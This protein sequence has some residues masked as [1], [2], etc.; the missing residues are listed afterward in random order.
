MTAPSLHSVEIKAFVP[1][2][3]FT[4]SL[5]FYQRIGFDAPWVGEDLAYL[6]HEDCSFLLQRFYLAAHAD[7]F[8]MH[9]LVTD[10]DAW[11]RHI[12]ASGVV[13]EFGVRVSEPADQPWRLR[14]FSLIDPSG[15]CWRIGHNLPQD[16]R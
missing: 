5:R 11:H 4:Q 3:D 15:V 7:N 13:E 1:A 16:G 10:A 12:V 9:L 2:R 6:R 14:D 8:L